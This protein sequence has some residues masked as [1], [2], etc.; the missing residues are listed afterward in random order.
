MNPLWRRLAEQIGSFEHAKQILIDRGHMRDDGSLTSEGQSRADMGNEG[1]ARDRYRKRHPT[2]DDS[3]YV[4]DP[5][6]NR[7][8]KLEIDV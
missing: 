6:T 3:E 7:L 4:Y 2:K 8:H 1:R 5:L